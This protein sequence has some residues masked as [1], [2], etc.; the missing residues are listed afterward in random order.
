[1]LD[2]SS[3]SISGSIPTTFGGLV[4]LEYLSINEN[5]LTNSIPSEFGLMVDLIAINIGYNDLNGTIPDELGNLVDLLSLTLNHNTEITGSIPSSLLNLYYMETLNFEGNMGMSGEIDESF[6]K[7]TFLVDFSIENTTMCYPSCIEIAMTDVTNSYRCPGV[8]DLSLCSLLT[9]TDIQY[10]MSQ[11]LV[12][13]TSS[14]ETSHP[15]TNLDDSQSHPVLVE[16]PLATSYIITFNSKSYISHDLNTSDFLAICLTNVDCENNYI[17]KYSRNNFDQIIV[18]ATKFYFMLKAEYQTHSIYS[19]AYW[20]FQMSVKGES[21]AVGWECSTHPLNYELSDLKLSNILNV[22]TS[23]VNDSTSTVNANF[24]YAT[25]V[26]GTNPWTGVT[27]EYGVVTSIDLNGMSLAGSINQEFFMLHTL[28]SIDLSF[29]SFT[30]TLPLTIGDYLPVLEELDVSQNEFKGSL[31]S[32]LGNFKLLQ[33]L[34]VSQNS[35]TGVLPMTLNGL[36]ETL[37]RLYL[38]NNEFEGKLTNEFCVLSEINVIKAASSS[39]DCYESCW[40]NN[41]NFDPGDDLNFCMPTSVPTSQPTSPTSMPTKL[42]V[43]PTVSFFVTYISLFIVFFLIII[44]GV[45]FYFRKKFMTNPDDIEREKRLKQLPVHLAIS[46]KQSPEKILQLVQSNLNTIHDL[47]FD[48]MMA[49]DIAL[50]F[51]QSD[52]NVEKS[53]DPKYVIPFSKVSP[54]CVLYSDV[55]LELLKNSLPVQLTGDPYASLPEPDQHGYA[56]TSIIQINE[57]AKNV[58]DSFLKDNLKYISLLLNCKDSQGRRVIDLASSEC[59]TVLL[60]HLYLFKK[61]ELIS[62]SFPHHISKNCII[63]I[64]KN[65]RSET[66][67]KVAIKFI[68]D[69][70][71]FDN[72]VNSRKNGVFDEEFVAEIIESFDSDS[73]EDV[74]DHLFQRNF[75]P[76]CIVLTLCDQSMTNMIHSSRSAEKDWALLRNITFGLASSVNHMHSRGYI[77]GDI[78]PSNVMRLGRDIM[79]IDLDSSQKFNSDYN[80]TYKTSAYCAPELIEFD[81]ENNIYNIFNNHTASDVLHELDVINTYE[82]KNAK[83]MKVTNISDSWSL[84][85]IFYFIFTGGHLFSQDINGDIDQDEMKNLFLFSDE[86]KNKKLSKI[87]DVLARNVVSLLLTK[88]NAKR[89]SIMRTLQHS[90]YTGKAASRLIGQVADFDVFISYRVRSDSCHAK[91]LYELLIGAGVKVWWDAKCLLPGVSWEDG[92]ADGLIRSKIFVPIISRDAI[93][94][95][96]EP[97]QSFPMLTKDSVCDNVLLEYRLSLE[98][99]ERGLIEKIYPL[100]VGDLD[101]N[102]VYSN[103]FGSGCHPNLSR[104]KDVIVSSVETKVGQ[105]LERQAYGSVMLPPSS[106]EEIVGSITINQGYFVQGKKDIAFR[107]IINDIKKMLN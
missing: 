41:D 7:L 49:F 42:H 95:A 18:H 78:Q 44:L 74:K 76:Y 69:K 71:C 24:R 61:Y 106:P 67:K 1:L 55:I 52:N 79:L 40:D 83:L 100:M 54:S 33:E 26:C 29:N 80:T 86:F 28:K 23:L 107:G 66:S 34:D 2:I 25:D 72:E 6:C 50:K 75:F 11:Q 14:Y 17:K 8:E 56:W 63:H 46:Q 39:F 10:K 13:Q 57:Y 45:M 35:F 104:V 31:P 98:L 22:S 30:G 65:R 19:N 58:V 20:G 32:S 4:N 93:N 101:E 96:T 82:N 15:Y 89:P 90:F 64:A 9:T 36:N 105:H 68:S 12:F 84:G 81:S 53:V 88:D 60:D 73:S 92:F 103:Y 48:N 87:K 27:C 70:S 85:V 3:N 5:I 59:K 91:I 43:S 47:D 51:A 99:Q 21:V 38:T 102:D 62:P 94:H 16:M 97:R 77:H 37:L